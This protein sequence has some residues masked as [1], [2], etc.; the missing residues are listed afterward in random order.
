V[1]SLQDDNKVTRRRFIS[2]VAAVAAGIAVTRVTGDPS[3]EAA[4]SITEVYKSH[5]TGVATPAKSFDLVQI[6]QDFPT[7]AF[8]GWHS[9]DFPVFALIVAGQATL[10][11]EP[12]GNFYYKAGS[13]VVCGPG[14]HTMGNE[15]GNSTMR[16]IVTLL[17]P[18]GVPA[19]VP[20]T[21]AFTPVSAPTN[22]Q[23]ASRVNI[24]ESPAV[25]D[26]AQALMSLAGGAVSSVHTAAGHEVW[27]VI[28]GEVT[29]DR[30]GQTT[31]SKA[32]QA[33]MLTP[34][35][36]VTVA[37]RGTTEAQLA[38]SMALPSGA[39]AGSLALAGGT[40]SIRPPSTGDGGLR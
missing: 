37:N 38:I 11:R 29:V 35:Q 15:I 34:G 8:L 7:L 28:Q 2:G 12:G 16:R 27:T 17:N 19:A 9:H 32:G 22:V 3:A 6:V 36:K 18:A 33:V 25:I 31:V 26:F 1:S 23:P 40:S 21:G 13:G 5:F 20:G 24:P 39:P 4:G 14:L 30:A 10:K